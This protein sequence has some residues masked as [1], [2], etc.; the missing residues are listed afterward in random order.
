MASFNTACNCT[1]NAEVWQKCTI[2]N[3]PP[4]SD[5]DSLLCRAQS[6]SSKCLTGHVCVGQLIV[7]P[8]PQS[9]SPQTQTQTQS[10]PVQIKRPN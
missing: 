3:I 9:L 5:C 2:A 7:K 1:V 4:V 6:D 10:N 8:C